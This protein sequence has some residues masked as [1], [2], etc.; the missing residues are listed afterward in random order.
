MEQGEAIKET[1]ARSRLLETARAMVLRG[2]PKFSIATL[3][4]EAGVS[5]ADFRAQFSGKTQ[6]MATL[7]A[8]AQAPTS[9]PVSVCAA[10]PA[11]AP[12]PVK[13]AEATPKAAPEPSVSTP[14]AWLER[15][16]RVFERALTALEAKAEAAGREQA[17]VIAELEE[18]LA[19]LE[20]GAKERRLEQ[21]P[22]TMQAP[23]PAAAAAPAPLTAASVT[24]L[25]DLLETDEG[26][27]ESDQ[28]VQPQA[29]S[30]QAED[31]PSAL[32]EIT[33]AP[34]VS[35]S[36]EAMAEVVQLARGKVR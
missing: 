21:R 27:G 8:E 31:K 4:A 5:R 25:E 29:A 34:V 28:P 19:Q 7:M 13:P 6:L 22:V 33:P 24:A 36:R 18:K 20:P 32:L 16:L 10:A 11:P 2:E 12:E 26:A 35:L 30:A 9:S 15:R 14:D 23:A 17:R 1:D 3:C